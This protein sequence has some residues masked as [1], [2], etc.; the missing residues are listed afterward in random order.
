[1]TRVWKAAAA[2]LLLGMPALVMADETPDATLS[3]SANTIAVGVGLTWGK[4]TL[5]Y[6]GKD[7]FFTL[8]SLS[9]LNL[10]GNKFVGTGEVYNLASLDDFNGTYAT[11]SAGATVSTGQSSS[12]M[13]N[14]HG[15]VIRMRSDTEGLQFNASVEGM[16]MKLA[17]N[18]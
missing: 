18:E 7:Y 17:R 2:A 5:H 10:G 16:T 13:K 14:Q 9:V 15:V 6:R 8:D 3:L 4:G 1:M 12:A 11:V